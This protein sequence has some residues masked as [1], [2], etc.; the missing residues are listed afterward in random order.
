MT[1]I[2]PVSAQ[3]EA[4]R[5]LFLRHGFTG[6]Q[7]SEQE[8][9]VLGLVNEALDTERASHMFTVPAVKLANGALQIEARLAGFASNAPVPEAIQA[10][11]W[12][13]LSKL[14]AQLERKLSVPGME[15]P[16]S[17]ADVL[18]ALAPGEAELRQAQAMTD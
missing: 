2:P 13:I 16:A 10:R 18:Q 7:C 14:C 8:V 6:I 1:P 9:F 15:P 17:G 5:K 4:V 11:A 3:A 12:T